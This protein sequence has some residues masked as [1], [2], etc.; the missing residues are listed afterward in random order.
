[1][2]GP[3]SMT[4]SVWPL[5]ICAHPVPQTRTPA[6]N[7]VHVPVTRMPHLTDKLEYLPLSLPSG[8]RQFV[9]LMLLREGEVFVRYSLCLVLFSVSDPGS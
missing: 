5:D 4:V 8:P 9:P 2:K 6:G 1:M 3:L 7:T